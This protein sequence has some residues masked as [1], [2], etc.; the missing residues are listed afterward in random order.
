MIATG[1]HPA[2]NF[3]YRPKV[4]LAYHITCGATG[5]RTKLEECCIIIFFHVNGITRITATN[6]QKP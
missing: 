5:N 4:L 2:S 3:D 6:H 1:A